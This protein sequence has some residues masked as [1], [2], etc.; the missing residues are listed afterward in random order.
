MSLRRAVGEARLEMVN[1]VVRG[2]T[3][4]DAS[5]RT[6]PLGKVRA[7]ATAWRWAP[8]VVGLA[9]VTWPAGS[10]APTAGIDGSWAIAL[11]QAALGRLHYGPDV[12]FTY[13]PLGFLSRP[14]LIGG[15]T[16]AA[17]VAFAGAAQ[18]ILCA[19][20]VRAARRSFPAVV[21]VVLVYTAAALPTALGSPFFLGDYLVVVAFCLAVWIIEAPSPLPPF[22]VVLGGFLAACQLLLKLNG[23]VTCLVLFVLTVWF[24]RPGGWRSELLF[25]ITLALSAAALWVLAG[26]ALGDFPA[27]LRES[28]HVMLSYTDAQALEAP[29]RGWEYG[30]AA[31]VAAGGAG[32]VGWKAR[33]LDGTRAAGLVLV[34]AF[35]G[36]AYFKE[37]FVR[38]DAHSISFFAAVAMALLAFRWGAWSRWIAA[39]LIGVSVAAVLLVPE[40]R[41]STPFHPFRFARL[42]LT[43]VRLVVD[44]GRRRSSIAEARAAARRALRVDP[45]LLALIGD[46]T[47]DVEPSET[48]AVWAY[49]LAWRPEPLIQS[50]I[51]YDHALDLV[52]AK[53][54]VRHGAGFVLRE[55][56]WPALDGK[57]PV[58]EA[59]ETFLALVCRYREIGATTRWEVLRRA[60]DRCGAARR[61]TSVTAHVGQAVAIPGPP[62]SNDIVFARMHIRTPL[63]TRLQSLVLKPFDQPSIRLDAERYRFLPSTAAGTLVLRMPAAAGMAAQFG[64]AVDYFQLALEHVAS[65]YRIDFFAIALSQPW[66]TAARPVGRLMNG[67]IVDGRRRIPIVAGA[68]LGHVDST[69]EHGGAVDVLGWAVS[70]DRRRPA[71][72][73][74]VFAGRRLVGEAPVSE[75]RPDVAAHFG[76]SGL[77]RAGFAV[78]VPAKALPRNVS[79]RV[80]AASG[81]RATELAGSPM[82]APTR[83]CGSQSSDRWCK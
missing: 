31:L 61:L 7:F 71:R 60:G 38:H 27:W 42:A 55:A 46:R 4:D 15:W 77:S 2:A 5:P 47:V 68:V 73:V 20:L 63:T 1:G 18:L 37:G 34:A 3:L 6:T 14:L 62:R 59:P 52:N 41:G 17:S 10:L 83:A 35:C 58:L 24:C 29:H 36:F 23:G 16:G 12:A 79:I 51:A 28:F 40:V 65:P 9:W 54:L 49:G 66:R 81:N 80:Y 76:R 75:L 22:V 8:A 70:G 72:R 78:S 57:Q 30:E 43:D 25:S 44:S 11:H 19:F 32:L 74:L 82:K 21:A 48:A 67:A 13:G 64:G 50:Y 33:R 56:V 45:Q 53:Q 39:G 69:D 26:N